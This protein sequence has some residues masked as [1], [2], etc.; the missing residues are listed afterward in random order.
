MGLVGEYWKK[1]VIFLPGMD[2]DTVVPLRD[3]LAAA[4]R[5]VWLGKRLYSRLYHAAQSGI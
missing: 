2:F 4:G 1:E 5:M 3:Q